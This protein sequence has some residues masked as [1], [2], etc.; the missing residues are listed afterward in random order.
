MKII[1]ATGGFDPLHSGHIEYLK[2]ARSLGDQLVVGLNSDDWLTRKKGRPFMSWA[3]RNAVLKELRCVDHVLNFDDQDGSACAF[4]EFMLAHTN[5]DNTQLV[6]VNGGDRTQDNIPEMSITD[7]RLSF[8]FGIGGTDKLNA[9]SSILR[10]W[11]HPVTERPWGK[12]TVLEELGPT[13]KVK[14]LTV[15]PGASLSMQRHH[16][17]QEL[18]FVAQGQARV[19]GVN[20]QDQKST[21]TELSE[22]DLLHITLGEWHQLCN[23]GD[24][25]LQIVELQFGDQCVETDIDRRYYTDQ[26]DI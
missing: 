13:V 17:R 26:H 11:T 1:L 10:N 22:H 8:E 4:I 12:Y 3:E 21:I 15:D 16:H 25:P 20:E 2:A 6:F 7:P 5:T 18:W 9:S 14:T 23:T 24:L 19:D